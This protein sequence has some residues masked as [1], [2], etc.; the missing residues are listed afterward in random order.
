MEKNNEKILKSEKIYQG[1]ILSLRI[2]TVELP[3]KKYSKRE[4][5]EHKNAVA[6]IAISGDEILMVKQYR[7]AADKVLLEIPAGLVEVNETPIE[8]ARRELEEETG[9][10]CGDI[11]Y[12]SEF[13]TS[14]GFSDEKVDLFLASDLH[15]AQQN[16]D[17]GEY[18]TVEKY[19]VEELMKKVRF[20]EIQ[21]AI[22]L[23]GIYVANEYLNSK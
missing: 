16:L 20:G 11:K 6:I 23:I 15:K 5:I 13:F 17:E 4:I 9:Y 21:N 12:V 22:T 14:P 7:R 3:N 1:K 18:L 10:K 8:A 2:D 19:N